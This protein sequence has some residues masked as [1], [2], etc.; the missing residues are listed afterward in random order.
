MLRKEEK[1]AYQKRYMKKRR[2]NKG[3]T[4]TDKMLDLTAV[5]LDPNVRPIPPIMDW[6][7]DPVKRCKLELITA[8][9]KRHRVTDD[10]R[11]GCYGPT[12]TMVGDLLDITT[13]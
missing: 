4:E 5:L 2:S 1:K 7:T 8:S 3:L 9:L 11:F 13:N 10:V 6:L 12:F